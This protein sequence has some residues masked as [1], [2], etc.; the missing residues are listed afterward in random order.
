M[1]G[2]NPWTNRRSVRICGM[3]SVLLLFVLA[4]QMVA[5]VPTPVSVL[6]RNPGDDFYLAS[7][8]DSKRYFEA[9][10]KNSDRIKLFTIGK[11]THGAD[12][13]IAVISSPENLSRLDHYKDI[14]RRLALARGLTDPEAQALAKEGKAIVHIDGGLHSTEVAG[15]Q[16][17]IQLAYRLLSAKNDPEVNS[18]LQNVI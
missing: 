18:I 7:Y 10:A 6:G 5:A 14:S 13:I 2:N 4:A 11:T 12:F 3:R 17:S 9:A 1:D 8:D 16:H 15:G